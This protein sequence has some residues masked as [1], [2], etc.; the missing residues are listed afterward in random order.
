MPYMSVCKVIPDDSKFHEPV[1]RQART[2]CGKQVGQVVVVGNPGH[3]K[4][5]NE[6]NKSNLCE[7]CFPFI[8]SVEKQQVT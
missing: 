4:H 2:S 7:E 3:P 1:Y 5:S 8:N 6:P